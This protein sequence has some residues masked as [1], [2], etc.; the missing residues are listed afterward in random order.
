MHT[1]MYSFN[2]WTDHWNC[3]PLY[4]TSDCGTDTTDS[5]GVVL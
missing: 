2:Y 4:S 3:S 5:G 1:S